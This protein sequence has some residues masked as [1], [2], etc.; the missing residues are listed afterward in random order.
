MSWFTRIFSC[1]RTATRRDNPK[2]TSD[3]AFMDNNDMFSGITE[4]E[5]DATTWGGPV[6]PSIKESV[7]KIG[8][9]YVR[10]LLKKRESEPLG[11]RLKKSSTVVQSIEQGS[12]L[13][14]FSGDIPQFANICNVNGVVPTCDTIKQL[15]R[16]CRGLS[17]VFIAFS[18]KPAD[19]VPPTNGVGLSRRHGSTARMSHSSTSSAAGYSPTP[20][21]LSSMWRRVSEV[22]SLPT[23]AAMY[24]QSGTSPATAPAYDLGGVTPI[25]FGKLSRD[26]IGMWTRQFSTRVSF[27]SLVQNDPED[28]G[29][30]YR[31]H[32]TFEEEFTESPSS[33]KKRKESTKRASI[34]KDL[35]N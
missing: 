27:P 17:A 34:N 15:L 14:K 35:N 10:I 20:S 6:Q 26:S 3:S 18:I 29:S 16:D 28:T 2:V 22:G 1:G 23:D 7:S 9:D 12:A 5:E 30:N 11:I 33:Y 25:D 4:A 21:Q 13:W 31:N 19:V 32:L 24:T 8:D